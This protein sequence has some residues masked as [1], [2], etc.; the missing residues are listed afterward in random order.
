MMARQKVRD[1]CFSRIIDEKVKHPKIKNAFSR[2][3]VAM[4]EHEWPQNWPELFGQLDKVFFIYFF[5]C[6]CF[7]LIL[8]EINRTILEIN[9][10]FWGWG[11]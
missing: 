7:F 3:V 11:T 4:A 8:L 2:C 6:F 9:F 10:F 5:F 1:E